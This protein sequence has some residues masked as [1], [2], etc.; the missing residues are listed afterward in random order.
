MLVPMSVQVLGNKLVGSIGSNEVV[1]QWVQHIS[2]S[3]C[4]P[5]Q[6]LLAPISYTTNIDQID[7]I[8]WLTNHEQMEKENAR[9]EIEFGSQART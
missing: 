1:Q 3:R 5:C 6:C 8:I 2:L 9:L 4:I 7:I